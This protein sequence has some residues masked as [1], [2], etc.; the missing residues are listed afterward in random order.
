ME[1]DFSNFTLGAAV[2]DTNGLPQSYF[3][4]AKFN[5]SVGWVQTIF[6]V[7]GM[8]TLL[9]TSLKLRGFQY[10]VINGKEYS[11][12]LVRQPTC[13][14]ALLMEPGG[15]LIDGRFLQWARQFDPETLRRNPKFI[16]M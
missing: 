14:V 9:M 10:V 3:V 16:V 1:H 4:P 12:V 5:G 7:L 6:Q 11:A 13:Y 2:F 8:K 15:E